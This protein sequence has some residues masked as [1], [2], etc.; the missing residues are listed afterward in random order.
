M[1]L[2]ADRVKMTVTS[3]AGGGT[4]TITLNAAVSPYQ[5]FA[6]AGVPN[7]QTVS[8]LAEEGTAW[9]LGRGT[10]TSSGTTLSRGLVSSST[11][12]LISLTSSATVSI[13]MLSD[14]TAPLVEARKLASLRL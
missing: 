3:V 9:E 7:G 8:Y 10:Y 2:W 11:G 4:G 1:G 14:D 12:S 13:V 5:S 6:S